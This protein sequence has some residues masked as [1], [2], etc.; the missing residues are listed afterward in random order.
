VA[1]TATY[2]LDQAPKAF[3]DFSAGALDKLAVTGS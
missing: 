3:A 1:I 2:P